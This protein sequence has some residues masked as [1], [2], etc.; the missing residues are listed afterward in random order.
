L[1]DDR[2]SQYIGAGYTFNHKIG[3]WTDSWHDCGYVFGEDKVVIVCLMSEQTTFADFLQVAE[4]TGDF[5]N[6]LF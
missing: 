3:N 5:V 4:I 1:Y 6:L 2:I